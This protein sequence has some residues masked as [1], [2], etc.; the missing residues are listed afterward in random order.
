MWHV[1]LQL[2]PD[3]DI[4]AGLFAVGLAPFFER[5]PV[6]Y[7]AL[8]VVSAGMAEIHADSPVRGGGGAIHISWVSRG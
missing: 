3:A 7:F 6:L 1:V 5:S 2:E 4:F 8:D